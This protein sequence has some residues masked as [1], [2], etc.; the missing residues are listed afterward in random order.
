MTAEE[1]IA[2][3][4]A[5]EPYKAV[6]PGEQ[7]TD[8]EVKQQ[9]VELRSIYLG[10]RRSMALGIALARLEEFAKLKSTNHE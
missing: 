3:C 7:M 5:Y 9:L 4:G 1:I 10:S 2:E 8:D 6:S